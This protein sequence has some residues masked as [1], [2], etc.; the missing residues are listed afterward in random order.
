MERLNPKKQEKTEFCHLPSVAVAHHVP[1]VQ[2]KWQ[3]VL[4]MLCEPPREWLAGAGGR[5]VTPWACISYLASGHTSRKWKAFTPF[6]GPVVR[7]LESLQF[8]SNPPVGRK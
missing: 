6:F 5:M 1:L 8:K 7:P 3:G 4:A 2:G